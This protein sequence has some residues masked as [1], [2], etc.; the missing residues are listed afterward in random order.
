MGTPQEQYFDRIL[1]TCA[2]FLGRW[3]D[4]SAAMWELTVSHKSLRLLL[5][6]GGG[7]GGNLLLSCLDPIKLRG[8]VRWEHSDLS[9]SRVPL[10]GGQDEGVLV[11]DHD[12]DVE[13]LCGG[14]E[15]KENVK[16]H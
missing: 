12:A 16:L 1:R 9:V 2:T 4:A 10:P 14:V 13:I 3:K 6:R 15:V 5:T 7:I 8:P 11:I